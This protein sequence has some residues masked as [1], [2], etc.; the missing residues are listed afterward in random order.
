MILIGFLNSAYHF[1]QILLF[2]HL[3]IYLKVVFLLLLILAVTLKFFKNAE[4]F[5]K[6]TKITTFVVTVICWAIIMWSL[7]THRPTDGTTIGMTLFGLLVFSVYFTVFMII[8]NFITSLFFLGLKRIKKVELFWGKGDVASQEVKKTRI[9][10]N[11]YFSVKQYRYYFW[12]I[13]FFVLSLCLL[14]ISFIFNS[15]KGTSIAEF[16]GIAIFICPM[17]IAFVALFTRTVFILLEEK[18]VCVSE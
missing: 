13:L 14:F 5:H 2:V 12:P 10:M 8:V 16:I 3:P 17:W 4:K 18:P 9:G 1:M 7:H 6:I 11:G 15:E